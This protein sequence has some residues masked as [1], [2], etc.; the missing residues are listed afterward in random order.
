[1]CVCA[2][3]PVC[4]CT[5]KVSRHSNYNNDGK[6]Q[7]F[8]E[9]AAQRGQQNWL[10]ESNSCWFFIAD[11]LKEHDANA[12]GVT[13][14]ISTKVSHNWKCVFPTSCKASWVYTQAFSPDVRVCCVLFGWQ[15]RSISG[16]NQTWCQHELTGVSCMSRRTTT[17]DVT[18]FIFCFSES[19]RIRL[20]SFPYFGYITHLY[21]V[22]ELP[23]AKTCHEKWRKRFDGAQVSETSGV[24]FQYKSLHK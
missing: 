6:L 13:G 5:Y 15:F 9:R 1:M 8:S 16:L 11:R 24:K 22:T 14:S 20:T 18:S 7:K 19:T 2:S 3:I 12:A 17:R 21:L 23:P 4:V 10:T